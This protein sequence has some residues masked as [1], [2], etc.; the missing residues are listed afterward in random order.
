MRGHGGLCRRQPP[1]GLVR[2]PAHLVKVDLD[3]GRQAAIFIDA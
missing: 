2:P 1:L 3:R